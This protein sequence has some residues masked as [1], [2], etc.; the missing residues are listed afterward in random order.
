MP[1]ERVEVGLAGSQAYGLGKILQRRLCL[2][3]C[4]Q[5][6]AAVLEGLPQVRAQA[7]F[8]GEQ[9]N[10]L[11]ITAFRYAL[12]STLQAGCGIGNGRKPPADDVEISAYDQAEAADLHGAIESP[13]AQED[14]AGQG[15]AAEDRRHGKRRAAPLACP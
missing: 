7:N 15:Q 12:A 2:S 4:E 3:P 5:Q 6:F 10:R 9:G 8:F 13:V 11:V 1:A 14:P